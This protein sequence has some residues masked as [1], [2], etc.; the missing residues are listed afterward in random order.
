MISNFAIN[1]GLI[2]YEALTQLKP[3]HHIHINIDKENLKYFNESDTN[4]YIITKYGPEYKLLSFS[5]VDDNH[6]VLM[7]V[8]YNNNTKLVPKFGEDYSDDDEYVVL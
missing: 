2:D 3:V 4:A 8:Y 5:K 1:I 7:R 6:S